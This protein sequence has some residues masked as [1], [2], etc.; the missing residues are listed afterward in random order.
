MKLRIKVN[1][2]IKKYQSDI[3]FLPLFLIGASLTIFTLNMNYLVLF[4]YAGLTIAVVYNIIKQVLN[5][6][7]EITQKTKTE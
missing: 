1:R 6:K 2:W 7:N 4:G 3:I 5:N